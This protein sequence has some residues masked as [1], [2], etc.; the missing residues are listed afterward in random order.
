M[1]NSR[2]EWNDDGA[3]LMGYEG[4]A[5]LDEAT[6]TVV[7]TVYNEYQ[8]D[9]AIE[10]LNSIGGG[11]IQIETV[12]GTK[13]TLTSNKTWDLTG[14][15]IQGS[16]GVEGFIDVVG[17]T[18]T[19]QNSGCYFRN[20]QFQSN[21]SATA[22]ADNQKVFEFVDGPSGPGYRSYSFY[23]CSW[24]QCTGE[25]TTTPNIDFTGRT[26][27]N[28]LWFSGTYWETYSSVAKKVG[29]LTVDI[30]SG[31]S[32]FIWYLE[33]FPS[34]I[35][36]GQNRVCLRGTATAYMHRDGSVVV[37][38]KPTGTF[39]DLASVR[40][41]PTV[42]LTDASTNPYTV[43]INQMS[44]RFLIDNIAGAFTFNLPAASVIEASEAGLMF[45]VAKI[46]T[47]DVTISVPSS[48]LV[49][50]NENTYSGVVTFDLEDYETVR[51]VAIAADKWVMTRSKRTN[52]SDFKDNGVIDPDTD[53]TAL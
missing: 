11:V 34:T 33:S 42:T 16:G 51:F 52:R 6:G 43:D 15:H 37:A 41:H 17:Y 9:D 7:F 45:E 47:Q 29:G 23:D 22:G 20:V 21:K 27:V 35:E 14:I 44:M 40:G 1:V 8:L 12:F 19:V 36:N 4:S 10:A 49:Y 39:S 2:I 3:P 53:T 32:A 46:G 26:G 13:I 50:G 28:F 18:I 5:G 38:E 31:M 24:V 25:L 30:G 48:I